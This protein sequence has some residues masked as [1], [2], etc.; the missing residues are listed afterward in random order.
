MKNK[1]IHILCHSLENDRTRDYHVEGNWSARLAKNILKYS[2][3]YEQEIW[4]AIRNLDRSVMFTKGG[5]KYRLFPAKTLHPVIESYFALIKCDELFRQLGKE[6]SKTTIIHIQGERGS[7]LHTILARFPQ[8]TTT[9]QYHGY[10]QPPWLE[11]LEKLLIIPIEKRNFPKMSHFFVH[12]KKRINYLRNNLKINRDKVDYHNVG[13][14]FEIFKPRHRLASRRKLSIPRDRFVLLYVGHMI[15][16]KGVDKI[17]NAYKILKEKYPKLFL[18]LVGA[19]KSDPL[20]REAVENA[21]KV[22]T[23][24][25]YSDMP[26]YY[27]AADL[28][29]FFG[30]AKTTNYAG[31]TTALMEALASNMNAISTNLIHFPDTIIDKIGLVPKNFDDFISKIDFFIT[32]PDV[33]YNPRSLVAPYT[34]Y[35]YQT[36]QLLQVYDELLSKKR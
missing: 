17:I 35:K 31:P 20:Y 24:L 2:N 30:D 21:D 23:M 28:Y 15:K 18:V 16:T 7:I 22:V 8:F 34:D 12:I 6:D 13:I 27:N 25:N 26:L 29:C 36:T 10:G 4:Y 14:D 33:R 3:K 1:I 5:I 9:V 11:W 32:H 19:Q